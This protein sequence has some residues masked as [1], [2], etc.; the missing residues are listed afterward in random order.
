MLKTN[1]KKAKNTVSCIGAAFLALAMIF[2]SVAEVNAAEVSTTEVNETGAEINI[3]QETYEDEVSANEMDEISDIPELLEEASSYASLSEYSFPIT[4]IRTGK[5]STFKGNDG[6]YGIIV[7][8]GMGSCSYTAS[9]LGYLDKLTSNMDMNLVN[10]YAIDIVGNSDETIRK[11]LNLEGVSERIFAIY[12]R[13]G[14]AC[15]NLKSLGF[16]INGG[17]GFQMP[18]VLFKDRTGNIYAYTTGSV[19]ISVLVSKMQEGGMQVSYDTSMQQLNVTGKVSYTYAYQILDLVNAERAKQGL[20]PLSMDADLLAAAMTRAAECSVYF[21]HTRPNGE[22]CFTIHSKLRGEN[23]AA[24]HTS[25]Q[26]VM[27]GW[28]NSSGHRGNI[29]SSE[30][31]NIGIGCFQIDGVWYW[32]QCFGADNAYTTGRPADEQRTYGI[33]AG[34]QIQPQFKKSS[35]ELAVGNSEQ[36]K[37]YVGS[38]PIDA[39][40]FIW[41]SSSSGVSVDATGKIT[42]NSPCT[43]T[44]TAENRNV[45]SRKVT[46]TV[47]VS[48]PGGTTGGGT[49]TGGTAGGGTTTGGTTTGGTSGGDYPSIGGGSTT[50]SQADPSQIEAFVRRMYNCALNREAEEAGLQDWCNRLMSQQIDGAGIS[51]GFIGSRE[52]QNR[53]LSDLEYLVVLYETFF[54]RWPD[55]E[56][57]NYWTNFLWSGG[58]RQKVLSGFVNSQEFSNLCDSYGIARGTMQANGSSIYRPGVRNFVLR[59]YTKALSREGETLGVEDWTNRINTGTMSAETV[60]KSFFNSQE[61]RNRNLSNAD[62]VEVLYQTFMDRA[63]DAA[64][65]QY[66]INKLNSGM[67]RT[68]VLEGFS[69]SA[70][71]RQIM[72][73]YGL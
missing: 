49:T 59:M 34:A 1:L 50:G 10:I 14:T 21:S 22:S 62:Y 56:G 73:Q 68:Q 15:Q 24:G 42:A 47:T 38:T 17:Q 28:M 70:E 69:R 4:D 25:P 32:T 36:L 65:K 55:E 64:G 39:D 7:L 66:W 16:R 11:S 71:F 18:M 67:S 60:A 72:A 44:I 45:R 8:G 51:Q 31:K 52:F 41:S 19:G 27:K 9:V 30:Y 53:N 3:E 57:L 43:A 48:N 23:I 61:F 20:S 46:Y 33:I 26:D 12:E 5:T 2:T 40:T 54:D 6:K 29:L 37:V 63:S 58:S 13:N 35:G